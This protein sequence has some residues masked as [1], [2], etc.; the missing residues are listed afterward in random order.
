MKMTSYRFITAA[1]L[2]A[3]LVAARPVH[4]RAQ[5]ALEPPG[6]PAPTMK[7]L[8]QTEPRTPIGE[9]PY[10][11]SAA[12]SYYLTDNLLGMVTIEADDVTLDLMGYRIRNASGAGI[13][14]PAARTNVLIRNG[15]VSVD[16]NQTA[17][18]LSVNFANKNCV[19]E[20]VRVVLTGANAIGIMATTGWLIRNC[21]VRGPGGSGT[22]ISA[23]G[24]S[25]VR[26]CRISGFYDGLRLTGTGALVENNLV[27]GNTQ[28]YDL[29]A[30]NQI[31]ILLSEIPETLSWPCS[32]KL[33]GSLT[34]TSGYTGITIASDDVTIGLDGHALIG[35]IGSEEGI[36][37]SGTRRNIAIRNG[38]LL[39]WGCEGV[40]A[41]AASNILLSGLM[42]RNNGMKS[43]K[44]GLWVGDNAIVEN[45]ISV[46]NAAG[47]IDI[48]HN[49]I[50][51]DSMA[52]V[53]GG[54]GIYTLTSCQVMHS[55]A[56]TN[57]STGIFVDNGSSVIGCTAN[58]NFQHGIESAG[59]GTIEACT[60]SYNAYYGISAPDGI[61]VKNCSVYKN[62]LGGI[63]VSE[64][65]VV[66]G[67]S[68]LENGNSPDGEAG[69]WATRENLILGNMVSRN[70]VGIRLTRYGNRVE[71]NNVTSN[72]QYGI[73]ALAYGGGGS[74]VNNFIVRNTVRG[75][76]TNWYVEAGNKVGTIVNAPDSGLING[77]TGGAGVGSTDPWANFTY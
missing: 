34:G 60:A 42:A 67:C 29:V 13:S 73:Q 68:V 21:H 7:T 16:A 1:L 5:G 8:D 26:D 57:G 48:G 50:V 71:G 52:N 10:T 41:E 56:N 58:Y 46:G 17:L 25:V 51:R 30:G 77:D 44:L 14:I 18:S 9:A 61:S 33:A 38:K 74:C 62:L 49:G 12:G 70:I 47:G 31:N 15:I 24:A 32:V 59:N 76:S 66:S 40:R 3:G 22:G 23:S 69:I 19:A 45:C 37:V 39:T 36:R 20:D 43:H 54:Y 55:V 11:I 6:A 28:N 4:V 64:G 53:N 75:S 27:Q 65:G 63:Y 2:L 72:A 35:V